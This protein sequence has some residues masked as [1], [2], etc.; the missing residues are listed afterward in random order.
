MVRSGRMLT[1][2]HV[3]FG[4]R[5]LDAT[6]ERLAER[7][8]LASIPGGRHTGLGTGNRIVPLGRSYIE[9]IAVVDEEE[10]ARARFGRWLAEQISS[11]DGLKGWCLAT[12]D[13]DPVAARLGL[14]PAE[15]TRQ[16]PDGTVLRWRLAG[17]E[18][19]MNDPWL[20]FFIEWHIHPDDHPGHASASHRIRPMG[21]AE[22]EVGGNAAHLERWLG[23][24]SLPV[25]CRAGPTG[26]RSLRIATEGGD[27]ILR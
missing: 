27:V 4:T 6:A 20:P 10:A 9:L 8:G 7:S 12:D 19:A 17:L 1:I 15:W 26:V 18:R 11:G 24:E 14:T 5:D 22:I 16:R 3:V 23:G 25:R 2:D 21:I 13:L